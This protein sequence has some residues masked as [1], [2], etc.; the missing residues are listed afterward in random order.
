MAAISSSLRS[1]PLI[2]SQLPA[3]PADLERILNSLDDSE[4]IKPLFLLVKNAGYLSEATRIRSDIWWSR[5]CFTLVAPSHYADPPGPI[6]WQC[7]SSGDLWLAIEVEDINSSERSTQRFIYTPSANRRDY[8]HSRS[9]VL[10]EYGFGIYLNYKGDHYDTY[11]R[12]REAL[13]GNVRDLLT[14]GSTVEL[15]YGGQR[16]RYRLTF[17]LVR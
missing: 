8:L 7:S 15:S 17:Q 6:R 11:D 5:D 12:D 1:A 10:N 13:L 9:E 16:H 2:S 3:V 4:F 14:Y